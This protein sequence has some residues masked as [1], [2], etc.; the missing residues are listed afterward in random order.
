M[1]QYIKVSQVESDNFEI[2]VFS[3]NVQVLS[4]PYFCKGYDSSIDTAKLLKK[5]S[6]PEFP[7]Y[8]QMI[9]E[10]AVKIIS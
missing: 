4:R 10:E 7:I 6:F 8:K 1:N 9:G 2:V 5:E 3:D